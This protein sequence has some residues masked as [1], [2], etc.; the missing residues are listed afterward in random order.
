VVNEF[1]LKR[2]NILNAQH[3]PPKLVQ[4]VCCRCGILRCYVIVEVRLRGGTLTF[5][6]CLRSVTDTVCAA[7]QA[8]AS[9]GDAVPAPVKQQGDQ[10]RQRGQ[11]AGHAGRHPAAHQHLQVRQLCPY[12]AG[13]LACDCD[14]SYLYHVLYC[15]TSHPQLLLDAYN[16]K[17]ACNEP[18]SEELAQL[19][20]I[21][22]KHGASSTG[23]V[24][25]SSGAG[26]DGGAGKSGCAGTGRLPTFTPLCAC[27]RSAVRTRPDPVQRIKPPESAADAQFLPQEG[28]WGP[29]RGQRRGKV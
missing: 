10:A 28:T 11:A 15:F 23:T 9:A 4:F 21:I 17:R 13:S 6:L 29:G 18:V 1:I 3:L 7:L 16:A 27:R 24:S 12:S 8:D 22:R 25:S 26:G 2:G 14:T 19:V 20:E 5:S